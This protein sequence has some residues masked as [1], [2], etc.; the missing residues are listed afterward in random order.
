LVICHHVTGVICD[1]PLITSFF[2]ADDAAV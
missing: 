2:H 1:G